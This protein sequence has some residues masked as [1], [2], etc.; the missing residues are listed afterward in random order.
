MALHWDL[1]KIQDYETLCWIKEEEGSTLNPITECLIWASIMVDL[2]SIKDLKEWMWRLHFLGKKAELVYDGNDYR[3]FTEDEVKAHM[4][5][6]T[7][8]GT[9]TRHQ[10]V[11]RW[12]KILKADCDMKTRHLK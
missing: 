2:D 11:Q 7:N 1:S 3:T 6:T 10:F 12:V 5:L 4:G 9:K 8:V